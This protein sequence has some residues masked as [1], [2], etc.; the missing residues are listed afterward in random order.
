MPLPG[1]ELDSC[2]VVQALFCIAGHFSV[3][4]YLVWW[5]PG[6]ETEDGL[7][8][9]WQYRTSGGTTQYGGAT[10]TSTPPGHFKTS[11][12]TPDM[13][14]NTVASTTGDGAAS[15]NATTSEETD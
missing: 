1:V 13:S 4:G 15:Y 12:A 6:G 9:G 11:P 5:S 8:W 2:V 3:W 10:Y 7:S 14:S